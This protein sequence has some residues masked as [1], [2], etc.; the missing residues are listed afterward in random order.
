M[1]EGEAGET[2]LCSG[3]LRVRLSQLKTQ[4]LCSQCYA[5]CSLPWNMNAECLAFKRQRDMEGEKGGELQ[6]FE[7]RWIEYNLIFQSIIHIY[8]I[9]KRS[10]SAQ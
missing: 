6:E 10:S 3:V 7:A 8:I 9:I 4:L 1:G 2:L 5:E